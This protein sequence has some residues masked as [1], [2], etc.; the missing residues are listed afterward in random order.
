MSDE[1][2]KK[3]FEMDYCLSMETWKK[4]CCPINVNQIR[5]KIV[6]LCSLHYK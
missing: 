5:W 6:V 4:K 2:K 3:L 1:V